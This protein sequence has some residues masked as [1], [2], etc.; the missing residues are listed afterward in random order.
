MTTVTVCYLSDRFARRM[1]PIFIAVIPTVIGAA[2]MVALPHSKGGSL[3]G[4]FLAET[5]GSSLALLYAW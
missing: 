3:A 1:L 5:Y 4:I 2:L